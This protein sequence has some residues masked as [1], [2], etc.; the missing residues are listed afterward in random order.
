MS[1]FYTKGETASTVY[2]LERKNPKTGFRERIHYSG[3]IKNKPKGWK[4]AN[5]NFK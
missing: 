3:N 1:A 2:M 5:I 4:L